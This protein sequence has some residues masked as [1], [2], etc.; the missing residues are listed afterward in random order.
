MKQKLQFKNQIEETSFW[1][2]WWDEISLE[3]DRRL[4]S[5]WP[6]IS[7]M[8][9][10]CLVPV[11]LAF[12]RAK[13]IQITNYVQQKHWKKLIHFSIRKKVYMRNSAAEKIKEMVIYNNKGLVVNQTYKG[14][15]VAGSKEFLTPWY[16]VT[17]PVP[18][19]VEESQAYFL[20]TLRT[21]SIYQFIYLSVNLCS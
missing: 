19:K 13:M 16:V 5:K 18:L 4:N 7:E 21:S 10:D 15:Y 8:Y 3:R 17:P 6:S 14:G 20:W 9:N 2:R 11:G 12:V 1:T